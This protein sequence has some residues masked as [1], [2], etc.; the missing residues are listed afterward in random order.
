M[1]APDRQVRIA[2]AKI[3]AG[4]AHLLTSKEWSRIAE[5]QR[6]EQQSL[7]MAM[8]GSEMAN[9]ARAAM[10]RGLPR[11]TAQEIAAA[12]VPGTVP[13]EPDFRV[14]N[15]PGRGESTVVGGV[16]IVG[17]PSQ[18]QLPVPEEG[19]GYVMGPQGYISTTPY[20]MVRGQRPQLG[21]VVATQPIEQPQ[22]VA[23]QILSQQGQVGV[24]MGLS[25]FEKEV[26]KPS[27]M[28]RTGYQAVNNLISGANVPVIN[29]PP[30]NVDVARYAATAGGGGFVSPAFA[31]QVKTI[32][33]PQEV[34][35]T[36][37]IPPSSAEAAR[38]AA[39]AGGGGFITSMGNQQ[40]PMINIPQTPVINIPPSSAEAARYGAAAGGGGF[41]TSMG[42]PQVPTINIPEGPAK[43]INFPPSSSEAARYAA[44]AGGGSVYPMGNPQVPLININE[45]QGIPIEKPAAKLISIPQEKPPAKMIN[46]PQ[47]KPEAKMINIPQERSAG[48]QVMTT[49]VLGISSYGKQR[50]SPDLVANQLLGTPMPVQQT[51]GATN[52]MPA[53]RFNMMP[54]AGQAPAPVPSV[55]QLGLGAASALTALLRPGV[56]FGASSPQQAART[57]PE[58][59]NA[60]PP[61]DMTVSAVIP[62]GT[63]GMTELEPQGYGQEMAANTM[64]MV[65]QFAQPASYAPPQLQVKPFN[66]RQMMTQPS[67]SETLALPSALKQ[68]QAETKA[69]IDAYKANV[70]AQRNAIRDSLDAQLKGQR[71]RKGELDIISSQ[72]SNQFAQGGP[73]Y[74][75]FNAG[76]KDQ[77][78]VFTSPK[79]IRIFDIE[80]KKTAGQQSREARAQMYDEVISRLREGDRAGAAEAFLKGGGKP[81]EFLTVET[82][83]SG[84]VAPIEPEASVQKPA[85]KPTTTSN[86][87]R[88]AIAKEIERRKQQRSG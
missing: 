22:A 39:A 24:P 40:V 17:G 2:Q 4:A 82:L 9:R 46:I 52:V 48:N 86:V 59:T 30:S 5:R 27:V 10:D 71:L 81:D 78:Y 36:I 19:Y 28:P 80:P 13:A 53:S 79:S 41:V 29:I 42:N 16:P 85:A 11:F 87:S 45:S 14:R 21:D 88:D 33:I 38:Y 64:G 7:P 26:N 56:F 75:T 60:V 73:K 47:E 15:I 65:Q 32:N 8:T 50:M 66:V 18:Y 83:S 3:A 1:D 54:Q 63:T 69:Q 77:G 70:T 23:D 76:G 67:V 58:Y 55:G 57:A 20:G 43:N 25:T 37:N 84:G 12:N 51:G 61:S 6:L 62:Q 68:Y 49:D 44:A 31:P 34:V 72:I 74:G 35:P